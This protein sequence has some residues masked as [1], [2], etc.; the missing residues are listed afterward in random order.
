MLSPHF[1]VISAYPII[2]L[3]KQL[4]QYVK[5]A[6]RIDIINALKLGLETESR[7]AGKSDT[8]LQNWLQLEIDETL[9]SSS[10][11]I[12]SAEDGILLSSLGQQL[13]SQD[14]FNK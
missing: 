12:E 1:T 7:R 3:S 11:L 4:S 14:V 8:A 5:L 6:D 10:V 13:P 2:R 9:K